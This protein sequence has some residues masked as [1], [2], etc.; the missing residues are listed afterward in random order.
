MDDSRVKQLPEAKMYE[1]P[2]PKGTS[3]EDWNLERD[4]FYMHA[5]DVYLTEGG[6]GKWK[7]S[8]SQKWSD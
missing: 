6:M 2:A 3:L 4:L 5:E 1:G 8:S 7:R